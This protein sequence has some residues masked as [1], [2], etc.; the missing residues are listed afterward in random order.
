MFTPEGS[1]D[2][3]RLKAEESAEETQIV[4]VDGMPEWAIAMQKAITAHTTKQV[5][6]VRAEMDQA[7]AMAMESPEQVRRLRKDG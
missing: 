4:A 2:K 1:P 6:G 5:Q 3:K 7:K